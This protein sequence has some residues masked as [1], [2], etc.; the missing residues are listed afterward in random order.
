MVMNKRSSHNRSCSS[1]R[2]ILSKNSCVNSSG[3]DLIQSCFRKR[4]SFESK[5]KIYHYIF[6]PILKNAYTDAGYVKFENDHPRSLNP[7][8][9]NSILNENMFNIKGFKGN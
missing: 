7:L 1:Q 6:T 5:S 2:P 8:S 3:R 4:S 9:N